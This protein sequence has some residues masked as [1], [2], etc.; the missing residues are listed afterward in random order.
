MSVVRK[1]GVLGMKPD[2]VDIQH[3]R[4]CTVRCRL[5]QTST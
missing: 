4:E 1:L 2:D 3:T 5:R